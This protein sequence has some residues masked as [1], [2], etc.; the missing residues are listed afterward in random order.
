MQLIRA[1][2]AADHHHWGSAA[3]ALETARRLAP[4]SD[5]EV[6]LAYSEFLATTGRV[7]EAIPYA[8][9][10]RTQDPLNL[11]ASTWLQI[12]YALGGRA[13][14][15]D[16]EYERSESL[17]GDHQVN[18]FHALIRLLRRSGEPERIDA[19]FKQYH[20]KDFNA[21]PLTRYLMEH[22]RDRASSIAEVRRAYQAPENLNVVGLTVIAEFADYFGD[23]DLALAALRR[24]YVDDRAQT[25]M[26]TWAPYV[27]PLRADSR[28]KQ[29]VRDLR[30]AEY[31][32]SS[33]NWGDF[34][35]PVGQA[36]FSCR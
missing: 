18:D 26:F 33:G 27:T 22:W 13:D 17:E 7:R 8:E 9:R 3:Q 6:Q 32:R 31:Y 10:V 11:G 29:M 20:S 19:Q 14:L 4:P 12:K 36:D 21:I 2:S 23:E 30:L 25:L 34:C 5:A 15:A 24:Q 16:A 35:Q 1:R 28:F